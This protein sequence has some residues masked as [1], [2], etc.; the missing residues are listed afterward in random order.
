[1]VTVNDRIK[2]KGTYYKYL[3]NVDPDKDVGITFRIVEG[4]C[5]V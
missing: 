5:L 3:I 4:S 1:M 2:E